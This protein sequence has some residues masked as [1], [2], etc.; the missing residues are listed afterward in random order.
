MKHPKDFFCSNSSL[1]ENEP[2]TATASHCNFFVLLGYNKPLPAKVSDAAFEGN[3]FGPLQK[4]V[5]QKNGKLL[6]IRNEEP[7]ICLVDHAAN[8]YFFL[9]VDGSFNPES[10]FTDLDNK[11]WQYEPFYLVCTN[12]NKDKCCALKGLPIFIYLSMQHQV[13]VYQCSHVGGDRFAANMLYMPYGIYYGR[14][15]AEDMPGI[16]N[17]HRQ[18]NISRKHY[19]GSARHNFL[20]QVAEHFLRTHLQ[21]FTLE[22]GITWNHF[23][24]TQE[25]IF[26]V[27]GTVQGIGYQLRFSRQ[28]SETKQFL[29]C[30]S[31]SPEPHFI[32]HLLDIWETALSTDSR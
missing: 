6:L 18:G 23:S 10:L 9:P 11:N 12:G 22:P 13:P 1:L 29:T 2:L 19:R 14:V 27:A 32:Y 5:K 17:A 4:L 26:E 30:Q 20:H 31:A 24:E 16:L 21:V 7:L 28:E 3:W 25:N 15:H 8:R